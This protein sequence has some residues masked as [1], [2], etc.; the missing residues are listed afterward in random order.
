M[1]IHVNGKVGMSNK[2]FKYVECVAANQKHTLGCTQ[3]TM[4]EV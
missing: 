1:C 4:F 3:I 2:L